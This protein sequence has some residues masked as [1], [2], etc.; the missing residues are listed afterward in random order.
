MTAQRYLVFNTAIHTCEFT[1]DL[2]MPELEQDI[3]STPH[4]ELYELIPKVPIQD[5]LQRPLDTFEDNVLSVARVAE[6]NGG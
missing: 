1:V 6:L 2:L 3:K 4:L 5:A